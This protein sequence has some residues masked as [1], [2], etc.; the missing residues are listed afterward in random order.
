MDGKASFKGKR[1]LNDCI[2]KGPKLLN[3]LILVL[4]NFRKHKVAVAGDI[5]EMFLQVGLY[6]EDSKFHRFLFTFPGTL[7]IIILEALVHVFGNRGSPVVVVFVIKC[8]AYAMRHEC[9]LAAQVI[10]DGS[11]VDDCMGSVP[12]EEEAKE[13]IQQLLKVFQRCSM[14]IHK[15]ASSS[16]TVLPNLSQEERS[17]KEFDETTPD[18]KALGLVWNPKTDAFKFRMAAA[19]PNTWTRRSALK[20]FMSLFDPLGL[21]LP[22]IMKARFLFKDTWASTNS[23]DEPVPL[24][25]SKLWT[26][27]QQEAELLPA[28]KIPRWIK[29]EHARELHVF[30]DAS[31]SAYGIAISIVS[32]QY[33]IKDSRLVFA[34]ARTVTSNEKTIPRAEMTAASMA[35]KEVIK[36]AAALSIPKESIEYHSDS[37]NALAWIMAPRR[38][39]NQLSARQSAQIREISDPHKWN[40][41]PT[42]E[43]PADLV[44]RGMDPQKLAALDLWWRGPEYL[45]TGERPKCNI[46]PHSHEPLPNEE[47]LKRLVGIFHGRVVATTQEEIYTGSNCWL[48]TI[49]VLNVVAKA[50]N[51][52]SKNKSECDNGL[53]VWI[54]WEQ[55]RFYQAERLILSEGQR[56][57]GQIWQQY[58][59]EVVRGIILLS[60]RTRQRQ[61]P[62]LHRDSKLTIAWLRFLHTQELKHA[63]GWKVLLAESRQH[64]WTFNAAHTV[65]KILKECTHCKRIRPP[66]Q[67]QR[68]APIPEF[69][70]TNKSMRAFENIAIDF[71]GP[72]YIKIGTGQ[73]RQARYILIICCMTFRA[74]RHEIVPNRETSTVLLALRI[75]PA[76]TEYHSLSGQTMEPN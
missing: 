74:M 26:K 25:V 6:P 61:L 44:T 72:W 57:K 39:L 12:T 27:W 65:K 11:I 56:P 31:Y 52:W 2:L 10:L 48:R 47:E 53:E 15:W 59:L 70:F 76:E 18:G 9:P 36:W 51:I 16:K 5:K 4:T 21:I 14:T 22:F 45:R 55:T 33:G 8:V 68:M 38:D 1:S 20:Y 7:Q 46:T 43:N 69:R 28:I 23:W 63:G 41:V 29:A 17:I 42:K 19:I 30:G 3:E 35:A 54:R 58:D 67:E 32:E 13:L 50:I 64:F 34:K 71:A 62:L 49:K 60:G 66:N 40:Y 75:S 24:R 37:Y 73:A